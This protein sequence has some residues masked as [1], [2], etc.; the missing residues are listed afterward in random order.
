VHIREGRRRDEL[1]AL[2]DE[3]RS[4][5]VLVLA[6]STGPEGPGPLITALTSKYAGKLRV[7]ITI[8][9]GGISDEQLNHVT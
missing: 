5:S 6:S 9:P 8:V 4:I 7:P 2:L 3:D 1:L